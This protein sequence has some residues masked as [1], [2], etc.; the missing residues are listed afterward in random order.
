MLVSLHACG[1]FSRVVEYRFLN[2]IRGPLGRVPGTGEA[3]GRSI[4]STRGHLDAAFYF[5]IRTL[6][7]PP[8]PCSNQ[9]VGIQKG[10]SRW[11]FR[12]DPARPGLWGLR[13]LD[14][15]SI[16][17]SLML[18]KTQGQRVDVRR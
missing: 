3:L 18:K 7:L 17:I 9:K 1:C 5:R 16:D 2:N 13:Y 11:C 14:P 6:P 15:R 8:P 12:V 10:I 4:G